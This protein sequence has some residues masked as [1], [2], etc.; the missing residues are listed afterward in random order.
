MAVINKLHAKSIYFEN[1]VLSV[2]K[3]NLELCSPGKVV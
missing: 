3:R 2:R 1:K